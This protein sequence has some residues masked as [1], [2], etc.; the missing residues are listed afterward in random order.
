M[1]DGSS[2]TPGVVTGFAFDRIA[3]ELREAILAGTYRVGDS[4]PSERVLSERFG[5]S[6][7][8]VRVALSQLV[9]E[10]IVDGRRGRPK[11]VVKLP[12]PRATFSEFHS[13]AQ[14]AL[15][16]GHEPGGAV[17]TARWEIAGSLDEELLDV[18]VGRRVL[19][20]TRVRTLDGSIVMLEQTRYPEWLGEIV[21]TIPAEARSVTQLLAEEHEVRFSHAEHRFGAES[22]SPEV[23][24]LLQVA[25]GTALLIH[26]RA[27][28]DPLGRHLEWST[29]RYIAGKIM[30]SVG[31]SWHSNPLQW[32]LP[33]LS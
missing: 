25:P 9:T 10:G 22:A 12:Q 5:V 24:A 8:T 26:R 15:S 23:A 11:Q 3:E 4:L 31:N 16:A 18:P 13:F 29:D 6:P 17:I 7:G 2:R 32:T 33:D 19:T 30:V 28:R 27:S 14:W 1:P 21:E 20:V